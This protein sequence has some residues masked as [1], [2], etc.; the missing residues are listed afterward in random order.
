MARAAGTSATRPDSADRPAIRA[1]LL[2]KV[3]LAVGD[4]ILLDGDWPR[5]TARSLLLLLATPGHSLPRDRV[6]DTLWPDAPLD[7][8]R[9]A[10]YI[11]LHAL[12]RVLE[13]DLAGGRASSYVEA[14]TSAIQIPAQPG[15]VVDVD[16]FEARLHQARTAAPLDRRHL[17]RQAVAGYGGD[18]LAD[19]PY[20]DWPVARRESLR[21]AWERAVLD[22]AALDLGAGEPLAAVPALE[23]LVAADETLEE[24]HRSLMHAFAAAGQPDRARRQYERCARALREQL[25]EEPSAASRDLLA[26]LSRDSPPARLHGTPRRPAFRSLPSP[27]TRLIGREAEFVRIQELL[28]DERVR[29]V[30]LTGP[31][32]IGKTHLALA[33]ADA[34]AADFRDGVVFVG[35]ASLRDPDHVLPPIAQ[36]IGVRDDDRTAP[37]GERLT[38]ALQDREILLVVDNV[39]HVIDAAPVVAGVLGRATGVK[40]LATSR[41][42]LRLRGEHE[43]EIPPLE[44]VDPAARPSTPIVARNESVALLV[45]RLRTI[46]GG[47]AV[48]AD[49]ALSLAT[50]CRRLDGIPLAIELAAAWSKYVS[51]PELAARL[52]HPL[53]LLT[54]G[55]R[56]L[57]PRHQTL[58]A[59]IAWSHDLLSPD[60]QTLFRRL[61]VFAGGF[62]LAAAEAVCGP[63]GSGGRGQGSDGAFS[64][65]PRPLP[66]VP[67]VLAG[68]AA[69][70]D[71]G[72]LHGPADRDS[73]RFDMLETIR[74]FAVER[75]TECGE[76]TQTRSRHAHWDAALAERAGPEL[77]GAGQDRWVDRLGVELDNLRA[78]L[79][80]GLDHDPAVALALA[81]AIWRFWD[82]RGL[83]SEG[84]HWLE[85]A[86][87]ADHGPSRAARAL[88]QHGA[89]TLALLRGDFDRASPRLEEARATAEAVGDNRLLGRATAGLGAVAFYLGRYAEAETLL[90]RGSAICEAAG[91]RWGAA[92]A[93]LELALSVYFLGRSEDA[94]AVIDR[95]MGDAETVGD[96]R[97]LARLLVVGGQFA[98]WE[99]DHEASVAYLTRALRLCEER[100]DR[101]GAARAHLRLGEALG[102]AG[103]AGGARRHFDEALGVFHDLGRV[104]SVATALFYRAALAPSADPAAN[105]AD[106]Q[107]SVRLWRRLGSIHTL[108]ALQ[109]ISGFLL[110]RGVAVPATRLCAA[111]A[112]YRERHALPLRVERYRRDLTRQI[113]TA[114]AVLPAGTFA[115]A[116][117]AGSALTLDQVIAE[118]L[119]LA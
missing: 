30:T 44:T 1:R 103:D 25:G 113:A 19:D 22:L 80:W 33:V 64:P 97:L 66:P 2:G 6:L 109:A 3:E 62:T 50:I 4:R 104:F 39:E 60:Q 102:Y 107:E 46:R 11:A 41:E 45:D 90:S 106:L 112:T 7:T 75:L 34:L 70:R 59:A 88:V 108:D 14:T 93:L 98:A 92:S 24:A 54:D 40:V 20:V 35:L 105:L 26:A 115:A 47:F 116:W 85:S 31:G 42:R 55:P 76:A 111:V 114:R 69:L 28:W 13:P 17:L 71:Q 37:L 84:Q 99:E 117:S 48:T 23:T 101:D 38:E 119:A 18:L 56:D 15:C 5:R 81:G 36:A 96:R 79:R 63:Q 100:D 21:Q 16:E 51:L 65:D 86:L 57:P 32:G 49:N 82:L 53:D 78:A 68:L 43:I 73:D 72:L 52:D 12:R 110:R 89:G 94:R 61:A 9:N 27:P 29:L 67:S 77:D 10:L 118:A 83:L 87:A 8:A 58:R 91:D 74:A 95:G